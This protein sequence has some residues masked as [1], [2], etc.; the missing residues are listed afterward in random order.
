V[1]DAAGVF[2][3]STIVATSMCEGA[4]LLSAVTYFIT[5]ERL[6]LIAFAIALL[7]MISARPTDERFSEVQ[8][9][10]G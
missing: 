2:V 8:S 1:P 4:A 10:L 9:A 6:V 3:T 5:G 7:G